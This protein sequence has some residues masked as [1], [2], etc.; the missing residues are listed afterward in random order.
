MKIIVICI[1]AF[2]IVGCGARDMA[3][4]DNQPPAKEGNA[5]VHISCNLERSY[6]R[7]NSSLGAG[8]VAMWVLVGPI[9]HNIIHMHGQQV[10]K[11]G[12]TS[13]DLS[14]P[15][16]KRLI[17]GDNDWFVYATPNEVLKLSVRS[18]GTREGL[19]EIAAITVS[20][21][22]MQNYSI[23][24]GELGAQVTKQ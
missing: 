17:W 3:T 18:G 7:S 5:L 19:T 15:W 21:E 20:D 22:P 6:V 9:S 14:T 8:A 2:F 16:R 11:D 12:L 13:A 1:A 10:T 24:L 4:Y 23:H